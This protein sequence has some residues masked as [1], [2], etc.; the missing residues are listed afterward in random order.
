MFVSGITPTLLGNIRGVVRV[1]QYFIEIGFGIIP[2]SSLGMSTTK[3]CLEASNHPYPPSTVF[4]CQRSPIWLLTFHISLLD[5]CGACVPGPTFAS[6]MSLEHLSYLPNTL[7][8]LI[9]TPLRGLTL[10]PAIS[11][12]LS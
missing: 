2:P 11:P 6:M 3:Y 1:L 7:N 8:D 12:I 5:H 9:H 10:Q 4:T